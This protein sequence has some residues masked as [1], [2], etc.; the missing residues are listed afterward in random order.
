MI[1]LSMIV[2]NEEKFL[3]G[4]LESVC[5]VVDE[6]I[7]V[8]T[9]STDNTINIAREFSAKL[10]EFKWNDNFS[11]A[12][13]FALSKSTEKYILYLDADERLANDSKT[14]LKKLAQNDER[15]GYYCRIL[16]IDEVNKKPS[17]MKYV[18]F[19]PNDNSVRFEGRI[20][21]QIEH[22]LL[23]NQ[24]SLSDS[25]IKIEHLG[26]SL[27]EESK[28]IKAARNLQLLL[29]DH[30]ENPTSYNAFQIAQT[31]AVLNDKNNAE[32]YFELALNDQN[33]KPEYLS[34]AYRYLA[35]NAAERNNLDKAI[36]F[37]EKSIEVDRYQPISILVLANLYFQNKQFEKAFNLFKE[38]Y[39]LNREFN[40]G[41]RDSFQT[42]YLDN[43]L[44]LLE[45]MH[46]FL[47]TNQKNLFE[48][49]LGYLKNENDEISVNDYKIINY[50]Y[51][52]TSNTD[53]P[54]NIDLVNKENLPIILILL[55]NIELDSAS[56]IYQKIYEKFHD[57][58]A[59]IKQYAEFNILSGNT[60]YAEMLL[61][62]CYHQSS[63]P[64]MI[65][66]LVSFYVK[67]NMPE[68]IKSVLETAGKRFKDDEIVFKQLL[69]LKDKLKT[70][71]SK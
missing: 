26:Y 56:K 42:I 67:N 14:E 5:D 65:F 45:A 47:M 59:F 27:S 12:R 69:I 58:T 71:I 17:V 29:K 66:Y 1:T 63:D 61:N 10:Y 39:Q 48:K 55:K 44:I 60:E 34:I 8:D 51:Q 46:V 43:R 7:I 62:S 35:V 24:I 52:R 36:K 57:N 38:A 25:K 4:C 32:S 13:N 2:K 18:R 37:C 3:R 15:K 11:D 28:K 64:S 19:F 31:Y 6:I 49:F 16:N 54:K 9:G 40:L 50:F 70:F 21:E 41:K 33:L 23:R 30:S 22:S 68:K 20:H 53:V